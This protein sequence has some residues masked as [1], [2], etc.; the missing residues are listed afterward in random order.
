MMNSI[1][2][3]EELERKKNSQFTM[4][5]VKQCLANKL[6]PSIFARFRSMRLLSVAKREKCTEENTVLTR[7]Q[8]KSNNG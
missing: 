1:R 6:I 2:Q 5:S 3:E 8:D 7:R 4:P